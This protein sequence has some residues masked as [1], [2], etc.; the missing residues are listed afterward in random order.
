VYFQYP[1]ESLA[2]RRAAPDQLAFVREARRMLTPSDD[3][4]FEPLDRGLAIYAAHEAALEAPRRILRDTYGDLV[5]VRKPKVRYMP[6]EPAHE[7]IMN[8]RISARREH[9]LALITELKRRGARILEE[10]T[11]SRGFIVRAEAPMAALLGLPARLDELAQGQAM[12]S[13]RLVRY[14][15]ARPRSRAA[16]PSSR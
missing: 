9:A 2:R 13:I 14:S 6:G 12:H 16:R 15:P 1:I 10:C 7:P 3:L 8:V 11:R 5:E 4:M